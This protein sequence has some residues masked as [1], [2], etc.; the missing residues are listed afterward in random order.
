MRGD[1]SSGKKRGFTLMELVV[2]TAIIGTLAAFAVPS[3][4][5]ANN[6]AK[7]AK[8]LDNVNI[9]G[10]AILN[11]YSRV[12][13][14]GGPNGNA[15][16]ILNTAAPFDGSRQPITTD[17]IIIST[18]DTVTIGE[19]FP[20]GLPASPF[21]NGYRVKVNAAGSATYAMSNGILTLIVSQ[22]PTFQVF[23]AAQTNISA[24]FT[25]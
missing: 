8:S 9:I 14:Y 10:S 5:Q 24:N 21:G 18:Q 4:I 13:S 6:K 19:I 11:A 20:N 22:K 17:Q 23:D 1:S 16:A 15:I 25:P 12:A 3:Y 7:G 2:S